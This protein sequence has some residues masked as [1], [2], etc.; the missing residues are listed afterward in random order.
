MKSKK[1]LSFELCLLVTKVLSHSIPLRGGGNQGTGWLSDLL[2]PQTK[3][4]MRDINPFCLSQVHGKFSWFSTFT[5]E[6]AYFP[7][8]LGFQPTVGFCDFSTIPHS[9]TDNASE[10]VRAGF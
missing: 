5:W 1:S 2:N 7:Q 8:R 10:C 9:C 4:V 6:P 3:K